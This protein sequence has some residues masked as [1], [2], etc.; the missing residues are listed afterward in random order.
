MLTFMID[1]NV[2]N[3][4]KPLYS[5]SSA[6]R[7][8][9]VSVHTL[10]MYERQGLILSYKKESNQRLYS[11]HDIERIKCLRTAINE[12]KFSIQAIKTIYS[13]IPCWD[14]VKCSEE[15]RN[16][17]PAFLE[18]FKPC[19]TYKHTDNRCARLNCRAC[20]VYTDYYKCEDIKESIRNGTL[21]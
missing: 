10:R 16:K 1:E 4:D 5:I 13:M 6:A 7:I 18:D 11:E 15:E 20:H 8:L 21:K 19:W 2:N 9:G 3:G 14:I 17:C 12:R